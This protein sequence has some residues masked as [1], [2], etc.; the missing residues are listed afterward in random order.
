M[1]DVKIRAT[2]I[3]FC[4]Y[5]RKLFSILNF[6]LKICKDILISEVRSDS[7]ITCVIT[8]EMKIIGDWQVASLIV[9]NKRVDNKG[10]TGIL[11]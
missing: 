4:G 6:Y 2:F 11:D 10:I 8:C 1:Y 5:A 3:L 9:L 7:L